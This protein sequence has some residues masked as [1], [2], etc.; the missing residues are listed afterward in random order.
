MSKSKKLNVKGQN[1]NVNGQKEN[2]K[3]QKEELDHDVMISGRKG[4]LGQAEGLQRW[5]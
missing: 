1:K 5:P 2:V 3:G 4:V